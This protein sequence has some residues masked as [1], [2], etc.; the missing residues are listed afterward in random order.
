MSADTSRNR[1]TKNVKGRIKGIVRDIVNTEENKKL[2]SELKTID[3]KG[4]KGILEIITTKAL[5]DLQQSN[6]INFREDGF[7]NIE[8]DTVDRRELLGYARRIIE[9]EATEFIKNT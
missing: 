8:K 1:L 3:N 6:Q 4:R 5:S 7:V 2:V 9:G